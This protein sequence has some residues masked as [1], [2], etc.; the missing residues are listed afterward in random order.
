MIQTTP[1]RH[2]PLERATSFGLAAVLLGLLVFGAW[3]AM[4]ERAARAQPI[5]II[6]TPT[7]GVMVRQQAPAIAPPVAAPTLAALPAPTDAPAP[8]PI[9][10]QPA[11]PVQPAIIAAPNTPEPA[12]TEK[13]PPPPSDEHGGRTNDHAAPPTDGVSTQTVAAP[14]AR[15]HPGDPPGGAPG[16]APRRPG[17]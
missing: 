13:R 2:D 9:V 12:W 4:S 1:I 6:A 11:A 15:A 5:Y 16:T 10:E 3:P 17:P 8:A 14:E 7:L